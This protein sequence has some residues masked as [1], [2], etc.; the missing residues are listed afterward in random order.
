CAMLVAV[1]C[2]CL[3]LVLLVCFFFSSSRRHTRSK[4][5]W[6]S[7]VCSSD[8]GASGWRGGR[9]ARAIRSRN[10]S[11]VHRLHAVRGGSLAVPGWDVSLADDVTAV[12]ARLPP[13]LLLAHF[14]S[15]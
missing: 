3:S 15:L 9:C 8:L 10:G 14:R 4:R 6:S 7:D 5:D 2:T 13:L 11:R 12:P 1:T